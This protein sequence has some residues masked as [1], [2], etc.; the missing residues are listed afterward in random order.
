MLDNSRNES[1]EA[2]TALRI[3]KKLIKANPTHSSLCLVASSEYLSLTHS[4]LVTKLVS[5]LSLLI[6]VFHKASF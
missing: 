4:T 6:Q 3:F 1:L 5:P 2:R